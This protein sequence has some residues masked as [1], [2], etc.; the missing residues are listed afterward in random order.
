MI[1]VGR[2]LSTLPARATVLWSRG[3]HLCDPRTATNLGERMT[4]RS[5]RLY[6]PA[7]SGIY[8]NLWTWV[9]LILRLAVGLLLMPHGAQ[10]LFGMFGGGGLSGTAQFFDK[11]GYSPGALWAP[12]LG[13]LEFFGGLLLAIGLFTRPI[14]LFLFIEFLFILQFHAPKGIFVQT[15]GAEHVILWASALLYFAIRGAGPI[16][17]D[18][19]MSREF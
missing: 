2:P 7:L 19:K 5:S 3:A 8:E 10:K 17:V 14:A 13:C 18:A 16:S 12:V 15:G 4:P 9:E 6:V 1:D 11:M